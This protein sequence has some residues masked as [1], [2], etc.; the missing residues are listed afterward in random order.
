[1]PAPLVRKAVWALV[2]ACLAIVLTVVSL[3]LIASTQIVRARIAQELSL[4]TGYRVTIGEAPDL[5]FWPSLKTVLTD[6]RF[7]RWD[8]GDARPVFETERLEAGLSA[9][10]ALAGSI[11]FSTVTLVRPVLRLDRSAEDGSLAL[12]PERN[13][14]LDILR[15]AAERPTVNEPAFGTI[16]FAEGRI[17]D[18]V[19]GEDIATDLSG[20]ADWRTTASPAL[21]NGTGVWRGEVVKFAVAL[22]A[23]MKF[24]AQQQSPISASFESD[25]VK[26]AFTGAIGAAQGITFEGQFE[27]SSPSVR[28]ALQWSRADIAPGSF[29][30]A[31]SVSG[32]ATGHGMSLKLADATLSLDGNPATGAIELDM[33]GP[34]PRVSGTLAFEKLDLGQFLAAFAAPFDAAS[35]SPVFDLTFSDQ[36]SLD[37]RLSATRATGIGSGIDLANV[38][39]TAQARSGFAAF[40]I[41]N[42]TAFGGEV[43]AGFRVDRKDKGEIGE[44]RISAEDIDWAILAQHFGWEGAQPQTKGTLNVILRSPIGDRDKLARTLEGTVSAKFGAGSLRDFDLSKLLAYK[45]GSG[46]FALSAVA[47]GSLPLEGAEFKAALGGGIARIETAK[48]WNKADVIRID[49]IVP[50]VGR[51]LALSLGVERRE[52]GDA[53]HDSDVT[54]FIGGSW[55]APYV[56]ALPSSAYE[57]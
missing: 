56:S 11:D 37:L 39:A 38:A 14:L 40:D 1:M 34:M 55:G 18:E 49:G 31:V 15:S 48:V 53:A 21:L 2:A 50:Y 5:V 10:R 36:V 57:P 20:L 54:Y 24:A 26:A 7:S 17:V 51:S 27:A 35:P 44:V 3:P 9:W 28:R 52:A 4:R 22:D 42:A 32:K 30:G 47:G 8:A 16:R 46:F 45:P 43:Q 41:S 23:P 25:P 19:S 6:V 12:L 29:M 33:D 13:R